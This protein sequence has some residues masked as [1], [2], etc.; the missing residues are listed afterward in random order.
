MF[1]IVYFSLFVLFVA[2]IGILINPTS[3]A[4]RGI[5][6]VNVLIVTMNVVELEQKVEKLK[7]NK[8]EEVFVS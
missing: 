3:N 4:A 1:P 2:V 5:L 8:S 6:I 7:D